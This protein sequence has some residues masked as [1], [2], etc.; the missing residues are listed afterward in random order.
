MRQPPWQLSKDAQQ[1]LCTAIPGIKA[2]P[3][4]DFALVVRDLNSL[5]AIPTGS[6]TLITRNLTRVHKISTLTLILRKALHM[7][8][9]LHM[10]Q[11]QNSTL[12]YRPNLSISFKYEFCDG[13]V[14][15]GINLL[16]R[17][18]SEVKGDEEDLDSLV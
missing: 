8:R 9:F 15:A 13:L 1:M 4:L 5:D 2:K 14:C 7:A 16:E 11:S 6:S 17:T 3:I 10:N 12:S 18:T